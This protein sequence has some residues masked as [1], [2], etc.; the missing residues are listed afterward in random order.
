MNEWHRYSNDTNSALWFSK[1]TI[2]MKFGRIE[3]LAIFNKSSKKNF[4]RATHTAWKVSVFGVILV[5]IFPHS[6]WIRR[7]TE[8]FSIQSKWGKMQTRITPNT[9][10]FYAVPGEKMFSSFASAETNVLIL[11]LIFWPYFWVICQQK[12]NTK[13]WVEDP[14]MFTIFCKK[15][16][17]ELEMLSLKYCKVYRVKTGWEILIKKHT[18]HLKIA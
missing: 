9:N 14:R 15:L 1:K 4:F 7:D 10:T 13:P 8:Y 3:T 6:D 16:L 17:F 11:V 2:K 5:R 12:I 18:R